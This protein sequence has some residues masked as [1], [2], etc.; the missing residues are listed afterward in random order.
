MITSL[1][2]VIGCALCTVGASEIPANTNSGPY[3]ER[4][5]KQV[6]LKKGDPWCAA[7]LYDWGKT[8][9]RALWPLPATGSCAMLASYA[10][11]KDVLMDEPMIGDAFLIWEPTLNR[12][13]HTGL[14]VGP[15]NDTV[16]GNTSGA[17]SREGWIVGRRLWTF[18]PQDKFIRWNSLL[19]PE[20]R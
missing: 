8:G 13:G 18:K 17:G 14:I 15:N 19:A 4:I 7:A 12:F 1:D 11:T 3:V 9:I 16:S 20:A 6:G 2:A 5:L 10:S